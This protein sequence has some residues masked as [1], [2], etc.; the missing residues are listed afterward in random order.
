MINGERRV[1]SV[2]KTT[3]RKVKL[4]PYLP[5]VTKMNLRWMK[6]LKLRS[7]AVKFPKE[8]IGKK[9]PDIILGND[10]FEYNT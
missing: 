3:C 8:N 1:S 4:D 6:D 5:S 7:D 10:L 2:G 9:F